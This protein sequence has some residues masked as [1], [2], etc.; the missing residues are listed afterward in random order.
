MNSSPV[1]SVTAAFPEISVIMLIQLSATSRTITRKPA[2]AAPS[3]KQRRHR[4]ARKVA[5][6]IFLRIERARHVAVLHLNEYM[7]KC[8]FLRNQSREARQVIRLQQIQQ[9]AHAQTNWQ[10]YLENFPTPINLQPQTIVSQT[11][12][13][14]SSL[15]HFHGPSKNITSAS[16]LTHTRAQPVLAI[17]VKLRIPNRKAD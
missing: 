15:C 4:K 6:P 13:L 7:F 2:R 10:R 8:D 5:W 12:L 17:E 11:N 3:P 16:E 9:R 14:R 1:S